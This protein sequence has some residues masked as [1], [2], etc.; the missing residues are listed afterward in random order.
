MKT[1]L[2]A[3]TDVIRDFCRRIPNAENMAI[4]YGRDTVTVWFDGIH[5]KEFKA[6]ECLKMAED[7]ARARGFEIQWKVGA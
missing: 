5:S 1:L 6:S 3:K 7:A 2:L 4:D